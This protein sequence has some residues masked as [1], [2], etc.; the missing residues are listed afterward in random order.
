VEWA[1]NHPAAMQAM[2]AEAR[3]EFEA[4]YTAEKN[5]KLLMDIYERATRARGVA[6][7][8]LAVSTWQLAISNWQVASQGIAH[9]DL[10]ANC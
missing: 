1:G 5:Y 3:R 9:H 4:K 2:G 6:A 7:P 8:D 10:I